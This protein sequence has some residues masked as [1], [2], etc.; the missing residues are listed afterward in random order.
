METKMFEVRDWATFIPVLCIAM[1]SDDQKE[2]WLLAR[3]GYDKDTRL[4]LL[5]WEGRGLASY[6]RNKWNDRTMTLAHGWITD[7]W[8]E[9]KSGDVVDVEFIL[10][11]TETIKESEQYAHSTLGGGLM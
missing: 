6:D 8:N 10:G 1:Q 5:V 11:E 9:L 2:R 3:L 4:I 7:H